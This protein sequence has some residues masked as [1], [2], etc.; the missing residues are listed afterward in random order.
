MCDNGSRRLKRFK[1]KGFGR[2]KG[3]ER[4]G[5]LPVTYLYIDMSGNYDKS[6]GGME[7]EA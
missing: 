1:G 6:Y 4:P 5:D 2:G 3:I 7:E